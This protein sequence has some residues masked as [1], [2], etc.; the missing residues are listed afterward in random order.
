M[1]DSKNKNILIGG[2]LAIILVMAVGY[3]AFATQLQINGTA[4]ITS[5]WDVHITSITPGTPVNGAV[6]NSASVAPDGLS[7][8]FNT[9]L[10]APGDSLTYTVVV[11]NAGS[12]DA[13]LSGLTFTPAD[14]SHAI[15][16]SY[17]GI[18]LNDVIDAVGGG[19]NT[20]TFTI[21]VTYDPSVTEQP[22]ILT[23]TVTMTLNFVQA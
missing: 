21:T 12:L 23:N 10:V 1:M 3:A 11:T 4:T 8:T 2:L 5:N 22:A 9:S 17:T 13:K 7:A 16:Y 20:K 19:T 18:L 6:H 14:P 15:T